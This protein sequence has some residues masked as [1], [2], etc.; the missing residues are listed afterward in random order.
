[1]SAISL[2]SLLSPSSNYLINEGIGIGIEGHDYSSDVQDLISLTQWLGVKVQLP[3]MKKMTED[4]KK[5]ITSDI[6]TPD[7]NDAL[8]KKGKIN[9]YVGKF[10]EKWKSKL[11]GGIQYFLDKRGIK[12]GRWKEDVSSLFDVSMIRI[13]I[14]D[15]NI[16]TEPAPYVSCT[17]SSFKVLDD[18]LD[19][20]LNKA[21]M[22]FTINAT[23]LL[24]RIRQFKQTDKYTEVHHDPG[25]SKHMSF[26]EQLQSMALWAIA[27]GHETING[28]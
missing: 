8:E 25:Y 4:E 11:L 22:T 17:Y 26:M 13:P 6:I 5:E 12:H 9:V 2:I 15:L 28:S 27:H 24:N 14:E 3:L 7:G 21:D 20:L 19:I 16:T 10:P 1:M 23:Y 18:W